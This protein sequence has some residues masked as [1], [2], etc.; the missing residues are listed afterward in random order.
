LY[1][2]VGGG[3]EFVA[4]SDAQRHLAPRLPWAGR[5][6]NGITT[7][8]WPYRSDKDDYVLFLGRLAEDKG[9]HVAIDAS[10]AAGMRL[11]VAGG[12]RG[13]DEKRYVEEQVR[14]RLGSDVELVGEATYEMK[15]ELLAG[16]RCL[17]FPILWE[18]PFG[19]VQVEAM[20]TGTPV[21][22]LGR[23]SVP[24]V[25][26]DGETGFVVDDVDDLPAALHR[27][28]DID[29][30]ACRRLVEKRFDVSVMA[31]GYEQLYARAAN[32]RRLRRAA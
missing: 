16:A 22:A 19:M 25:V 17:I 23:G 29:P 24:E 11:V 26:S 13:P 3:V 5:V 6:Y 30:E 4:I 18:E 28:A 9:L 10:R 27:V 21:V 7:A 8:E 32:R 1:A 15:Q 2:S 14:P 12:A 31:A 20:A